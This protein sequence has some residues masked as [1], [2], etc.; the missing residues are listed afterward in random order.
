M[1][2]FCW[3]ISYIHNIKQAFSLAFVKFFKTGCQLVRM[4]A[5]KYLCTRT[6]TEIGVGFIGVNVMILLS[7]V[8]L[9]LMLTTFTV[10]MPSGDVM[11]TLRLDNQQVTQT[12][13]RPNS[14]QCWDHRCTIDLDR[15]QSAS[16]DFQ[17][18]FH[19]THSIPDYRL[20]FHHS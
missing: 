5:A 11:A 1:L 4:H 15:V 16:V 17:S 3:E 19:R 20:Y 6:H 2:V 14:Q 10:V 8:S 13:W 12:A 7:V 18:T 9:L